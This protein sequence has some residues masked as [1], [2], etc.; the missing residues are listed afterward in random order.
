MPPFQIGGDREI[1]AD[2][3]EVGQR[4]VVNVSIF[5]EGEREDMRAIE[6]ACAAAPPGK[7]EPLNLVVLYH[8][9]PIRCIGD[10]Q[11]VGDIEL[12]VDVFGMS[13]QNIA[14]FR[15]KL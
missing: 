15:G 12:Q 1:G 8:G 3:A 14:P 11:V 4:V 13:A 2:I 9:S 5:R 7:A 10:P 6:N